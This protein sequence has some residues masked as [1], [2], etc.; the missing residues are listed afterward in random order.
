MRRNAGKNWSGCW[1]LETGVGLITG[2]GRIAEARE[3]HGLALAEQIR[4]HFHA[5][6][7]GVIQARQA[8]NAFQ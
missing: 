7:A 6:I 2:P 3:S 8:E 5:R 1:S 4:H